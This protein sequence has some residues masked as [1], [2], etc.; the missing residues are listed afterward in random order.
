MAPSTCTNYVLQANSKLQV[1][2]ESLYPFTV[3]SFSSIQLT[4]FPKLPFPH[5]TYFQLCFCNKSSHQPSLPKLP[6]QFLPRVVE[7]VYFC[8]SSL[9]VSLCTSMK[10]PRQQT[11][12]NPAELFF[13]TSSNCIFVQAEQHCLQVML[14]T[15]A[16][17]KSL[18]K[19]T[20]EVSLK[21]EAIVLF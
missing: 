7:S 12:T 13:T 6:L 18:S 16:N 21:G 20:L 8:L 15:R 11:G 9:P 17:G 5:R 19:H 10:N 2:L 4:L 3:P 1:Y 14:A